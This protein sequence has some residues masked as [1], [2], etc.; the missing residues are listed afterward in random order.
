MSKKWIFALLAGLAVVAGVV[1][2]AVS[3]FTSAPAPAPTPQVSEVTSRADTGS[4]TNAS[5]SIG[6]DPFRVKI[7]T[8]GAVP[9]EQ[10][11][12]TLTMTGENEAAPMP[13][14]STGNTCDLVVKL[15]AGEGEQDSFPPITFNDLG[16]FKYVLELTAVSHPEAVWDKTVRYTLTMTVIRNEKD[17]KLEIVPSIRNKDGEKIP[18]PI[19]FDVDYP[20]I[21]LKVRKIWE[22]EDNKAGIRPENLTV[23]LS[24]GS[25]V[26]ETVTLNKD[27]EWTATVKVKAGPEYT[28]TEEGIDGYEPKEGSPSY[29]EETRTT[30]FTNILKAEMVRATVKKVW[31]DA[32]NKDGKRPKTGVMMN[33]LRRESGSEG[34]YTV[35]DSVTLNEA[36]GWTA[37]LDL[38]AIVDGVRMEYAWEEQIPDQYTEVHEIT[39]DAS[40][41][42]VTFTNTEMTEFTVKKIWIDKNDPNARPLAITV[43]ATGDGQTYSEVL[44]YDNDWTAT[45]RL[46][47]YDSAGALINYAWTESQVNGY[48]GK[49]EIKGNTITFT[50]TRKTYPGPD[51]TPTPTPVPVVP[52]VQPGIGWVYINVGDCLE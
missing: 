3:N 7:N 25:K 11:S 30:T 49:V 18:G 13:E 44:S 26:L 8:T 43:Y 6:D 50:N 27:N 33:L 20:M 31:V 52:G 47:K 35:I 38:P 28:W 29:D 34:V 37:T 5:A 21:E 45:F 4:V 17:N 12:Y 22:D 24:E 2:L 15:P 51:P 42:T 10:V 46:P 39:G 1:V 16:T 19:E 23:T 40:E 36:N 41:F 9:E 32:D 48:N 14:G